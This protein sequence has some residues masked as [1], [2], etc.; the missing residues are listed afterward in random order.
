MLTIGSEVLVVR[1]AD[2]VT[3]VRHIEFLQVTRIAHVTVQDIAPLV[4]DLPRQRRPFETRFLAFD[5]IA[6]HG[7]VPVIVGGVIETEVADIVPLYLV[8]TE[9]RRQEARLAAALQ[10]SD[11][12]REHRHRHIGNV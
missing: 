11:N 4:A 1:E 7:G 3:A 5:D 10:R 12:H 6:L 9:F 2:I 8:T